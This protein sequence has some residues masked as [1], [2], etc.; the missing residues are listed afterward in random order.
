VPTFVMMSAF[1]KEVKTGD[2]GSPLGAA[3]RIGGRLDGGALGYWSAAAGAAPNGLGPPN[4]L[5]YCS[6]VA[7]RWARSSAGFRSICGL[8]SW[9]AARPAVSELHSSA[10]A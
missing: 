9:W 7:Y 3:M 5:A 2:R 10:S 4:G 8:A 1:P 6:E